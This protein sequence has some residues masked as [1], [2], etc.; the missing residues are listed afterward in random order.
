MKSDNQKGIADA[1]GIVPLVALAGNG[2]AE[3]TKNAAGALRHL[4]LNADNKVAIILACYLLMG[5]GR[6][7]PGER[8][9]LRRRPIELS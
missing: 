1:G 9:E 2:S 3:Q 6:K 5:G 8:S 4:A 7:P